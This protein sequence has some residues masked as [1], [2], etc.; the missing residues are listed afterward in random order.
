M[1]D[2]A[3]ATERELLDA[4]IT[5]MDKALRQPQGSAASEAQWAQFDALMNELGTRPAAWL[6]RGA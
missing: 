1:S 4:A 2:M 5:A 3:S 6:R